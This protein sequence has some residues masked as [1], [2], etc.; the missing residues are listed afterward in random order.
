MGYLSR[1]AYVMDRF[2]HLMGLHGK[3]F[4]PLFLGFGC[5][6]PAVLGA[7][8]LEERRARLLTI[9]LAP[10]VPCTA[11][12]AV[13]AFLAPA[14]FASGGRGRYRGPGGAQPGGPG[15]G[16]HRRQQGGV[17]GRADGVHHGAA[18][19]PRAQRPHRRDSMSG[20]TRRRFLKKAGTFILISS[21]V[22]WA[23]STPARAASIETSVLA[24]VGQGAGA[25]RRS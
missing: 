2:M 6:V 4:L 14:F 22:V 16:R 15:R 23:L 13:L 11:R 17:Q 3:S 5:N 20:T 9:L 21:A 7:R 1:G 12:L 10:L 19:L 25:G 24:T 8:I 18:A